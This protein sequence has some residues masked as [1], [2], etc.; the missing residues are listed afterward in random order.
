MCLG[1]GGRHDIASRTVLHPEFGVP[2][3]DGAHRMRPSVCSPSPPTPVTV[4][5]SFTH[6]AEFAGLYAADQLGFYAAEGLQVSFQEGG[7]EV[8]FHA[9]VENGTAQFGLAQPAD[10][11]LARSGGQTV[12]QHRR[13]LSSQPDGIHRPDEHRHHA[14]TGLRRQEDPQHEDA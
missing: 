13:D 8:D 1:I 4:Q 10:V 5:L 14:P 11:I 6:Q 7:P 9:P 3:R 12:A 2:G